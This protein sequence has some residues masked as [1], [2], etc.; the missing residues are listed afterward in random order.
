M[1]DLKRATIEQVSM[2]C[3]E[4]IGNKVARIDELNEKME[5]INDPRNW[6]NDDSYRV[7]K[8]K[9]AIKILEKEIAEIEEIYLI[10]EGE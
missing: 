10:A 4:L 2:K 3:E 6:G 8:V 9:K 1:D 7:R 5:K